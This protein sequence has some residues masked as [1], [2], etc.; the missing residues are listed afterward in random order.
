MPSKLT[1]VVTVIVVIIL[2]AFV[3]P[4]ILDGIEETGGNLSGDKTNSVGLV[5]VVSTL[6]L[7]ATFITI[8]VA[9]WGVV[10]S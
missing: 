7:S 9:V 5:K 2:C 10:K 3:L 8:L 1:L 6:T 4:S